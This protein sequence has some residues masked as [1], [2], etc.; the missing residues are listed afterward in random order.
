MKRN[1]FRIL[2][3][4]ISV[5]LL[6]GLTSCDINSLLSKIPGFGNQ[7][8]GGE[9]EGE[10]GDDVQVN[11]DEILLVS[12]N[13]A[14]FQIVFAA[15]EGGEVVRGAQD[16]A[17]KLRQ[18]GVEVADPVSDAD[19]SKVQECEILIGPNIRNRGEE[20][21]VSSYYLGKDGF[22]VKTVGQRV[23]IAGGNA[24]RTSQ[25]LSLFR[26]NI[27][28]IE[29]ATEFSECILKKDHSY[30]ETLTS[31][32]LEELTVAGVDLGEYTLIYDLAGLGNFDTGVIQSFR[33]KL[34]DASGRYL[35]L[36][37]VDK[38][39]TYEYKYIIRYVEDAGD[40]GFRAYIDADK[41]FIVECSYANAFEKAF[42][43]F[44]ERYYYNKIGAFNAQ[45][46]FSYTDDVSVVY[47]KEFGA[48]G[49]DTICDY[50]AIYNAHVY[51]NSGGQKVM[52]DAGATYYISADKFTADVPVRTDVDW[53]GATFII[54]DTG[55]TA[56]EHRGNA[57]FTM[58]KDED[59]GEFYS[60]PEDVIAKFGQGISLKEGDTEI[61][62]L[63]GHLKGE[64]LIIVYNANHRDYIRHGS[65]Q[66]S[67]SVRHE[68]L[69]INADGTLKEDNPVRFDYDE[70]TSI[71]IW[72]TDDEPIFVGNGIFYN[73]CCRT[74]AKTNFTV[75][76]HS[77]NRGLRIERCNVTLY[78]LKHQMLDEPVRNF[79]PETYDESYPYNRGFFYINNTY[80]LTIKDCII[81]GHTTYY[82]PKKGTA[83][84]GNEGGMNYVP[85]GSYDFVVENSTNIYF[86]NMD[87]VN[88]RYSLQNGKIVE[89]EEAWHLADGSLWGI[90]SSNFA[91]NVTFNGCSISRIDAHQGFFNLT[92]IDTEVGHTLNLVGGGTAYIENVTKYTGDNMITTR[93]D[94]GGTFQGDV[95]VKNSTL[96]GYKSFKTN[97]GG[98]LNVNDL[99]TTLY[100]LNPGYYAA[101]SN[102]Y[103]DWDF[104]Y[105]CYMPTTI[106]MEGYLNVPAG[107]DVYMSS[108]DYTAYYAYLDE[109][110]DRIRET[111][112]DY[113]P[114]Q[115][116]KQ[117]I[118][119]DW[120]QA[121]IPICQ[122]A[123]PMNC[124][125]FTEIEVV[126]KNSSDEE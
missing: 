88:G 107:A 126:V 63:E 82:E 1:L 9:G 96:L 109:N 27:L 105:T 125:M 58:W 77:Y 13:V 68:A 119:K 16:L 93:D 48:N 103:W 7:T 118:F 14:K 114:Y 123:D 38:M 54:D 17:L 74:V 18:L 106:T 40:K 6:I 120:T 37:T 110:L 41:N 80:N 26:K 98:S 97:E 95:I 66:N 10:G 90:M 102:G 62:W 32:L 43:E 67:G 57:L 4:A 31:Y 65:N 115:L 30:S 69:T 22:T 44:A 33:Q 36:G 19:A 28:K 76:Y 70:I 29:K 100:V 87:Q 99:Y 91:K 35:D 8:G 50:E 61:P 20:C 49:N 25:A 92:A 60:T 104:G 47:Y 39:D 84:S 111:N 122:T 46:Q 5:V 64:S 108:R 2:L 113:M 73:I 89:V 45:A 121:Q 86:D 78:D 83:S 52:G 72:T 3:L 79:K 94:Y 56:Y 15:K 59:N 51:A 75:K 117:V 55:D 21:S 112:P 124:I 53:N 42:D 11:E 71:N 116:T 24:T 23:I 85:A 34:Y 81:T 101:D 12:N